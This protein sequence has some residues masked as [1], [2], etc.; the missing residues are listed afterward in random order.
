MS[1]LKTSLMI[2]VALFA[3]S[4]GSAQAANSH[5]LFSLFGLFEGLGYH[6]HLFDPDQRIPAIDL[7]GD[8]SGDKVSKKP[9]GS[10]GTWQVSPEVENKITATPA[11]KPETTWTTQTVTQPQSP[12]SAY[13]ASP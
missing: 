6:E 11:D 2:G 13:P 9:D 5:S 3:V 12:W 10:N 8:D 4:V 1:Q 7:T